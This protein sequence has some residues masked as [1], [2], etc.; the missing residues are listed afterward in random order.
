MSAYILRESVPYCKIFS[1]TF[2]ASGSSLTGNTNAFDIHTKDAK[3]GVAADQGSVAGKLNI[4]ADMIAIG[5]ST[6]GN[7]VI[8]NLGVSYT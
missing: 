4:T 3:V 2:T 5:S 6:S 1:G 7:D 8:I